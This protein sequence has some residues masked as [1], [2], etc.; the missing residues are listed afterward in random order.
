M[1]VTGI[2]DDDEKEEE[3]FARCSVAELN[4]MYLNSAR[5]GDWP[6]VRPPL[7][8]RGAR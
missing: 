8:W 1:S 5:E 3:Y 6:E 4:G 7:T 2:G